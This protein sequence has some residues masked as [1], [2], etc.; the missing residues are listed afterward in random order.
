MKNPKNDFQTKGKKLSL[1]VHIYY[2][3]SKTPLH[4]M[5]FILFIKGKYYFVIKNKWLLLFLFDSE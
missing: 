4:N 2:E 5:L 1:Y 3:K